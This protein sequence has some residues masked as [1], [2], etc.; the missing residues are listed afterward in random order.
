MSCSK[1]FLGDLPELIYDILTFLRNDIITLHSCILVNKLWCRLAIPLLWEDPFST[2]FLD[3][4]FID[5]Y[6]NNLDDDLRTK[7]DKYNRY[8]KK[9]NLLPSNPLFNYPSFIK[10]LKT[11]QFIYIT[12]YWFRNRNPKILHSRLKGIKLIQMLLIETFIRNVKNLHTLE[13][14]VFSNPYLNNILEIILHNIDFFH[15]IKNLKLSFL[16]WKDGTV[17]IETPC[18]NRILQAINTHRNLKKI[19]FNQECSS[20]FKLLF[21]SNYSNTLNIIVLLNVNFDSINLSKLIE[22]ANVLESIHMINCS[23]NTSL[24]KQIANLSKP[25]KLKSLYMEDILNINSLQ[26]LFQKSGDYL[27]NF[28]YNFS[29]FCYDDL[30]LKQQLLKLVAKYCKNIKF[31][32]LLEFQNGVTY[33]IFNLIENIKQN[34]KYLNIGL[35]AKVND[36]RFDGCSSIILQNLGKSLSSNLEHL[37]LCLNIKVRDF[38][39][40]L[41]S[42]QNTFI[43]KLSIY[44][45]G[46]DNILVLLPYLRN[47]IMKKKCVKYLAVIS[48]ESSY[49]RMD[50]LYLKD[51]VEE[52][53]LYNIE[54]Q[55]YCSNKMVEARGNFVLKID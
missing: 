33:P 22:Q 31:L 3:Y 17:I 55:N 26:L 39:E 2:P 19:I 14:V 28:G 20:Y 53:E 35:P 7:L 49:N 38:E 45:R 54:V 37:D 30:S 41:K 10:Y 43:K 44:S 21:L 36:I 34:L 8:K 23:I 4:I 12:E 15:N 24:D 16:A 11:S 27:E 9:V 25:F 29:Y 6:F 1:L 51:E 18:K 13:I 46:G 50:L 42:I 5:I 47:Y 52:F 48:G 40:F 32:D